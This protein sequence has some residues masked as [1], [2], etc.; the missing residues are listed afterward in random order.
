MAEK[1]VKIDGDKLRKII[2]YKGV[3]SSEASR[4]IGMARSYL[5]KCMARGL[6]SQ[7]SLMLLE[8]IYGIKRADIEAKEEP[9]EESKDVDMNDLYRCIYGAVYSAMKKALEEDCKGGNQDDQ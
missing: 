7:Q 6:M 3:S 4:H 8:S 2:D 1:F 5:G 9:K